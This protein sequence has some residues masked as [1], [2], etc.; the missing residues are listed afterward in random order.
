MCLSVAIRM[1]PERLQSV[2]KSVRICTRA[3]VAMVTRSCSVFL[4]RSYVSAVFIPSFFAVQNFQVCGLCAASTIGSHERLTALKLF[5]LQSLYGRV[6]G[7]ELQRLPA[8]KM[9]GDLVS[10]IE[11]V[12]GNE[13][14]IAWDL[15]ETHIHGCRARV[16]FVSDLHAVLS[17]SRTSTPAHTPAG[18]QRLTVGL[19][20]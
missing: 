2:V 17:S 10:V 13:N 5:F 4:F 6:T 14:C 15:I 12:C 19:S 9:R 1:N 18:S 8:A 11:I 20:E 3:T 16:P 7:T